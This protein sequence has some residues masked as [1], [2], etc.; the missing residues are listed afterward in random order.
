LRRCARGGDREIRRTGDHEH[1]DQGSQFTSEAWTKVLKAE[2][3]CISI[4][5]KGRWIDND[6][7]ERLSRRVKYE[8]V[9]LRAYANGRES[10]GR[11][12]SVF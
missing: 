2:D 5:G 4:D 7:I 6:F 12:D 8:D 3:S 11:A 9:Y 10:S 1:T